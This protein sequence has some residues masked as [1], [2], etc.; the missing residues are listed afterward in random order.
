VRRLRRQQG[1]DEPA[2]EELHELPDYG[3]PG[4][5]PSAEAAGA[6]APTSSISSSISSGI[7]TGMTNDIT[8]QEVEMA[9]EKVRENRL[10]RMAERQGLALHKSRRRDPRALGFGGYMIVDVATNAIV[11]G[12]LD[13]PRA[14]TLEEVEQ[15]LTGDS[16]E[17]GQA[18]A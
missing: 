4:A 12:E 15:Y 7:I 5:Y 3:H 11:A 1:R 18:D 10:R 13:S 2:R 17:G 8:I 9:E 16:M 14:L 6:A